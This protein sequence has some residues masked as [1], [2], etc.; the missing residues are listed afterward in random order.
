MT[1]HRKQEEKVENNPRKST[2]QPASASS[3]TATDDSRREIFNRS[4]L[5]ARLGGHGE[6]IP[7]F[8]DMFLESFDGCLPELE[9]AVL[10]EDLDTVRKV[11]HTLK[12]VAGNIGAARIHAILL[13]MGALARGGDTQ[14]L[15]NMLTELH[16]EYELFKAEVNTGA[17][18]AVTSS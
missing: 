9:W 15:R 14:G 6:M 12:G 2:D 1:G 8:I 18:E 5:L 7:R 4:A 10:A 3:G 13:D 16:G 17:G 11:A